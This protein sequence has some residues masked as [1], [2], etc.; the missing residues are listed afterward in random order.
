MDA[1]LPTGDTYAHIASYVLIIES[2]SSISI[3]IPYSGKF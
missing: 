2:V 1:E 3:I